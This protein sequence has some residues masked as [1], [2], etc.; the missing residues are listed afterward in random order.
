M[1]ANED[2]GFFMQLVEQY[3]Q[4]HNVPA[5]EIAAA[6]GQLLQGDTPFLLQNKPQRKESAARHDDDRKPRKEH[7]ERKPR[8]PREFRERPA[9]RESAS[10]Q[11]M[12][13]Y[14]IEVGH[15]HKV[16]PGNI[17]GAIANEVGIDSQFIGRIA[18]HD[19]YSLVDLPEGMPKETFNSL[20]KVWVSGQQ[21]N[22]T[23][24]A[25]DGKPAATGG[26]LG[27]SKKTKRSAPNKTPAGA[28]KRSKKKAHSK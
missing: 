6:L 20:K 16:K 8:E 14:R 19:D 10:E 26:T 3:Q 11:G 15:K 28:K 25:K 7:K 24:L 12:E 13:R 18:I 5:L 9:G 27:V 4:E 17:V 22:I 1:L 21:L 23:R 2:L